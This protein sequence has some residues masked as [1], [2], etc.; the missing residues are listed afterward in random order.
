MNFTSILKRVSKT[1]SGKKAVIDGHSCLTYQELWEKINSAAEI[2]L[3]LNITRGDR[4]LIILPN[5]ISFL[6]FHLAALKIGAI[7]VPVKNEYRFK[8]IASICKN[9]A[10]KILLSSN[11]WLDQNSAVLQYIKPKVSVIAIENIVLRK[12]KKEIDITPVKNREIATITYSYF[13]DSYP[14][15]AANS[16]ANHIYAATGIAKHNGFLTSDRYFSNLPMSHVFPLSGSINTSLIKGGTI[17]IE[18]FNSPKALFSAIEKHKVTIFLSVPVIYELLARYKRKDKYDFSSLRLCI[19]G[20]DYMSEK[21]QNSFQASLKTEIVQGYGLTETLPVTC[22]PHGLKNRPGTLGLP[23]RRDIKIKIGDENGKKLKAGQIGEIL[24]NSPTSMAKYYGLPYDSKRIIKNGWLHSG[25]IGKIDEDGYLHFV[26]LKK[27]IYN[28][29]GNKVDP[30]EVK[31]VIEE[32]PYIEEAEIYLDEIS[33]NGN[34][35]GSKQICANVYI[36]EGRNV[37]KAE[38]MEFCKG[39]IAMYK[40]PTKIY[41][42]RA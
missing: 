27:K 26:G 17:V 41:I 32:H 19:T 40:I 11:S 16:H 34:I 3:D 2:Y 36:T 31:N 21:L 5:S 8:E 39:M 12:A 29:F 20:G 33:D 30:L 4:I 9:C 18:K 7:S 10:P 42:H 15:G 14:K 28:I 13:G 1:L 22:N 35:I 24:I 6:I 38:I 37:S 23:G 25:D